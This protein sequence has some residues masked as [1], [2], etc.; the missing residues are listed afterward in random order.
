MKLYLSGVENKISHLKLVS[1]WKPGG[2]IYKLKRT[3]Y[4]YTKK[5]KVSI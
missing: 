2:N 4:T 1:G 5:E 3:E